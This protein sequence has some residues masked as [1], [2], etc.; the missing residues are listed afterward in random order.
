MQHD[1]PDADRQAQP[2]PTDGARSGAGRTASAHR[3]VPQELAR[4][5]PAAPPT[6]APAASCASDEDER[7]QSR[8]PTGPRARAAA[9]SGATARSSTPR[10]PT[11]PPKS[12]AVNRKS[13]GEASANQKRPGQRIQRH[14]ASGPS[15]SA[16]RTAV[17]A[18]ARARDQQRRERP[19]SARRGPA[20]GSRAAAASRAAGRR[21]AAARAAAPRRPRPQAPTSATRPCGG[22]CRSPARRRRP[23]ARRPVARTTIGV[24][25]ASAAA[26]KPSRSGTGTTD[27][28][29]TKPS[30]GL[31]DLVG[32]RQR[33]L[34]DER[35][36]A[37]LRRRRDRRPAR[38]ASAAGRAELC[39]RNS[40]S[41]PVMRTMGSVA[42]RPAQRER[43]RF[44]AVDA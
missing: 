4:S 29:M 10:A 25:P 41:G 26:S 34:R 3:R 15:S 42:G 6:R 36:D 44:R 35:R 17:H 40:A 2:A 11:T 20:P 32:A 19:A 43:P 28:S 38:R 37:P 21:A 24:G 12:S 13:S 39:A 14:A 22:R 23:A 16:S 33:R 7:W 9:G 1:E 31:G 5:R 30:G 18:I 8:P 27:V